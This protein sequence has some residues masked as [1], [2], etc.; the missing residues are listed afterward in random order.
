MQETF[1]QLKVEIKEREEAQNHCE[2]QL[3]CSLSGRLRRFA[4]RNEDKEFSAAT[5]NGIANRQER[6]TAGAFEA[7]RCVLSQRR[8]KSLK[9]MLLPANAPDLR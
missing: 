5:P 6:K 4:L 7:G 2:Q 1:E 9:P 8:R 3:F